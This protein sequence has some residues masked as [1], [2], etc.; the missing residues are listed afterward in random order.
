MN[1][2]TKP[3][4]DAARIAAEPDPRQGLDGAKAAPTP[5]GSRSAWFVAETK[6]KTEEQADAQLQRQAFVSFLPRVT[7]CTKRG[8]HAVPLFPGYLFVQFNLRLGQWR[9]ITH[10]RGIQHIMGS[11]PERPTALPA[12]LVDYLMTTAS[13]RSIVTELAPPTTIIPGS[14]IRLTAGPVATAE[15]VCLWSDARRV[16]FLMEVMGRTVETDAAPGD[17]EPA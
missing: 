15:G 2:Y 5:C 9:P 14:R 10:T 16:R 8:I 6:P 13:L 17:V 7:V 4:D 3:S 12:G 1:T 11:H